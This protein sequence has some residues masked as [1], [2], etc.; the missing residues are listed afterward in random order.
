MRGDVTCLLALDN[1]GILIGQESG[2]IDILSPYL[3]TILVK[4]RH[5]FC[6]KVSCLEKTS[7]TGVCEIAVVAAG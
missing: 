2:Y 4:E 3:D 6:D 5:P 7:R 1:A